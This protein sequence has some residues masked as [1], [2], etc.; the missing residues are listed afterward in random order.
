[1]F[2]IVVFFDGG[3]T[4]IVTVTVE[5]LP[6]APRLQVTI[7]FV[8]CVRLQLPWVVVAIPKAVFLGSWSVTETFAAARGPPLCTVR[9]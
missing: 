5:P 4:V 7:L 2:V 8:G 3:V 1:M 6:I 9:V